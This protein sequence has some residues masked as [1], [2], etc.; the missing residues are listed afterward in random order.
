MFLWC[1]GHGHEFTLGACGGYILSV[2]LERMYYI[3]DTICYI[4]KDLLY[5]IN[6]L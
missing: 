6:L 4:L 2:A 3:I 1:R 5:N